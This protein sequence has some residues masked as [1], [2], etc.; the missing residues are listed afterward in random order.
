LYPYNYDG[1]TWAQGFQLYL[2]GTLMSEET[3]FNCHTNP[4]KKL[5]TDTDWG[6]TNYAMNSEVGG[7]GGSTLP[8]RSLVSIKKPVAAVVFGDASWRSGIWDNKCVFYYTRW[9]N[10][11]IVASSSDARLCLGNLV[12]N[13]GMNLG[14]LDGHVIYAPYFTLQSEGESWFDFDE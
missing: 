13:N 7:V 5:S 2:G 10:D 12:H 6:F 4:Y 11:C 14:Y 8:L 1:D 3:P 9:A